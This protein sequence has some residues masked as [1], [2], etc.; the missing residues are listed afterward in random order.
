VSEATQATLIQAFKDHMADEGTAAFCIPISEGKTDKPFLIVA[1][2]DRLF[3]DLLA[4][5]FGAKP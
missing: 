4:M 3:F 1:G 2:E 5:W